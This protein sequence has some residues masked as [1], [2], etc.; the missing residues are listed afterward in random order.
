MKRV[1]IV[2]D[3]P[4]VCK[5]V[6]SGLEDA[7]YGAKVAHDGKEAMKLLQ[8][9]AFDL[10]ILDIVMPEMNGWQ[11]MRHLRSRPETAF[12]PVIFLTS[13][14]DERNR[15]QGFRL[16]ADDFLP[17]PFKIEELTL[18]V[19][20]VLKRA[21]Q[22]TS[23]R[24]DTSTSMRGSLSEIGLAPL[25]TMLEM[26][27]KS[28]LLRLSQGRNKCILYLKDGDVIRTRR[29]S[30]GMRGAEAVFDALRWSEGTFQFKTERVTGAKEIEQNTLQLL[31]E[32]SRRMDERIG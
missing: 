20:K 26:E 19:G 15:V 3:D 5:L 23:K 30:G 12:L 8:L 21:P 28:G 11:L 31:M 2:D 27:K 32:A 17:K 6:G 13:C 16:G 7:G 4:L 18:R 24:I 29:N 22:Q 1:L 9:F 14:A 10:A 25:L